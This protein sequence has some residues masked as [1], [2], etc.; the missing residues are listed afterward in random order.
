MALRRSVGELAATL[1]S[2]ARTRFELFALEA[3]EQKSQLIQL[4]GFVLGALL[5]FTLAVLVFSIAVA[6]YFW[7]SDYRYPALFVLALVYAVL[8]IVLVL[9]M[10]R[11]LTRASPPFAATLEELQHD[12][13]LV[14]GLAGSD[15][16]EAPHYPGQQRSS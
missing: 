14:E 16:A 1:L 3:A 9:L 8:G 5:F 15:K 13:D 12:I 7:P 6:L 11:T 2:I 4:I 10:R